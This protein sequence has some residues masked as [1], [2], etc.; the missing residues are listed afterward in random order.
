MSLL[1]E[2]VPL[3]ESVLWTIQKR[4][5]ET[6]GACRDHIFCLLCLLVAAGDGESWIWRRNQCLGAEDRALLHHHQPLDGY[7]VR[8]GV[9]L[10]CCLA[11][12]V[13]AHQKAQT[14]RYWSLAC[15]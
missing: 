12:A 10:R 6:K 15:V 1:E 3:S 9:C 4:F 11:F 7:P 14:K 5:Y 13:L 8:Q 2:R